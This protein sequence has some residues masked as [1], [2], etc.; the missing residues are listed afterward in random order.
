MKFSHKI[1]LRDGSFFAVDWE[2]NF[3]SLYLPLFNTINL[4]VLQR[5]SCF[6]RGFSYIYLSHIKRKFK[7][8]STVVLCLCVSFD[9]HT[10]P[11]TH[12]YTAIL[13]II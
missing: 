6:Q 9:T 5:K 4:T 8:N 3:Y 10:H 7:Q 13:G 12:T 1:I 11:Y 2:N